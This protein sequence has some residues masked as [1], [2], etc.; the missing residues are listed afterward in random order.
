MQYSMADVAGR[1]WRDAAICREADPELVLSPHNESETDR[2]RMA[3][4]A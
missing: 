3:V 2:G 1:D 4:A